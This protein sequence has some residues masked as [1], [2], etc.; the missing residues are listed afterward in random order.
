MKI[1]LFVSLF[2][3]HEIPR[4]LDCSNNDFL[5]SDIGNKNYVLNFIEPKP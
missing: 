3:Q 2:L 5:C 4:E 1:F